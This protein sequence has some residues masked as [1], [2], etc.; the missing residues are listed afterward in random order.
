VHFIC[1]RPDDVQSLMKGLTAAHS[2]MQKDG[3][4]AL[5]HA[6]IIAY[7]F[8]F[9]HPFDDGNGRIHRFLIHNILARRGFTP[10][11][12]MLPISAS[13]LKNPTAYDQ[14]LESFSQPL[15]QVVEYSLNDIG[16][17]QVEN[18]TAHWYR[19]MDMTVQAEALLDFVRDTIKSEL[20]GELDFLANYDAAKAAIQEIVDLPDRQIDLFINLCVQNGGK[21]S[22]RKRESHFPKLSNDEVTKMAEAVSSFFNNDRT[23]TLE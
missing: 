6:A 2:R 20:A 12:L 23:S 22:E 21:L 15:L 19:Y 5:V 4:P 14:S 3:F 17:M 18:E 16:E 10:K 8:V 9:I 7:A 1:P 13:M 11:G